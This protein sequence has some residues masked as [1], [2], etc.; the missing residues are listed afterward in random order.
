MNLPFQL[1]TMISFKVFHALELATR[2]SKRLIRQ[3]SFQVNMYSQIYSVLLFFHFFFNKQL[4]FEFCVQAF[5][6]EN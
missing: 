5:R 4:Q 1:Q 2:S 3:C 6:G